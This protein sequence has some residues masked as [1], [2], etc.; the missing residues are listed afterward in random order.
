MANAEVGD[1]VYEDDPTVKQLE[2]RF[3]L[4]IGKEASLFVPSGCMGNQI[5]V[6]YHADMHPRGSEL[7]AAEESHVI[8]YENGSAAVFSSVTMRPIRTG[9]GVLT[10]ALVETKIRKGRGVAEP[11]TCLIAQE[12][13]SS[14]GTVTPLTNMREVYELAK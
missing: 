11:E 3:A 4:L 10:R 14:I 12:N 7:L 13:P 6:M 5:C 9:D 1:D 2:E 8:Q